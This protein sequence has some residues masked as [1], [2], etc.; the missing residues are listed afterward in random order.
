M[1]ALLL[2]PP[3]AGKGTQ[4][5]RLA[6]RRGVLH[7][8]TGDIL[9][10]AVA[11]GTELGRRARPYMD[12]GEYV[13]DELVIGMVAERLARPDAIPGF[14][15]DGFPRTRA[16]ATALDEI[17]A[18]RSLPLQAI[19]FLDVCENE[20]VARLSGRRTCP[21]CQRTYHIDS[22][23]PKRDELCDDDQTQLIT[24][25]DDRPD[26]VRRRFQVY[27][28]Q[29][30]ELVEHYA[31][32]GTLLRVDGLGDVESVAERID[33]VLRP[34]EADASSRGASE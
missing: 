18:A 9:R 12:R 22:S 5:L 31:A 1:R 23:P 4:A 26:T 6:E 24:R 16:Q 7:V 29:T 27:R 32:Q 17:L 3:G 20:L 34:V 28:D 2:G 13:P 10:Q 15:L 11:D 14:V 8:A 19:V 21:A 25:E 30:A 33:R